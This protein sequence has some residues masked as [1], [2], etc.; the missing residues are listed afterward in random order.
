MSE[1]KVEPTTERWVYLGQRLARDGRLVHCWRDPSG[2][3]GLWPKLAGRVVGGAYQVRVL[4]GESG[5]ARA[6]PPES[7][8]ELDLDGDEVLI[9]QA[10]DQADRLE[11]R[12]ND[13]EKRMAKP[14]ELDHALR[15]L[16]AIAANCRSFP[17]IDALQAVVR[18]RINTAWRKGDR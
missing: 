11:K 9:L 14:G 4:R 15:E 12:K 3:E 8:N 17:E 13:A 2:S 6:Y 1:L 16:E 7:L 10:R 5:G 18:A